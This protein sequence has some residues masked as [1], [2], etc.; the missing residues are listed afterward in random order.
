MRFARNLLKSNQNGGYNFTL[1]HTARAP[2]QYI[3]APFSTNEVRDH[4]GE[5]I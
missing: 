3:W 2:I 5:N 1:A 4:D